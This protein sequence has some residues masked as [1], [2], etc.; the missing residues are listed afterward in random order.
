[1]CWKIWTFQPVWSSPQLSLESTRRCSGCCVNVVIFQTTWWME[2]KKFF[3][4]HDL[5]STSTVLCLPS[6][7]LHHFDFGTIFLLFFVPW[8]Q[9]T[10]IEGYCYDNALSD[11]FPAVSG[12]VPT[13]ACFTAVMS[14]PLSGCN[15]H[16]WL[17]SVQLAVVRNILLYL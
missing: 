15:S 16:F 11:P 5:S 17:M 2:K 10:L 13:P 1:L 8:G 7:P 4:S 6:G 3:V 12:P 14:K 9:G